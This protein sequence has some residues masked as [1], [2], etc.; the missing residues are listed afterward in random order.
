M[1]MAEYLQTA[2]AEDKGAEIMFAIRSGTRPLRA[3]RDRRRRSPFP[4]RL[5][6]LCDAEKVEDAFHAFAECSAHEAAR[7]SLRSK[8][9]AQL[10]Q[11]D[12]RDVFNALMGAEPL[13]DCCE[14][15]PTR[16]AV[17]EAV[18]CFWVRVLGTRE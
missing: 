5:C 15:A 16:R 2:R 8:L 17:T 18:K 14:E 12:D 1:E 10:S 11:V 4:Q 3:D 9:P 7:E 6:T 13:R